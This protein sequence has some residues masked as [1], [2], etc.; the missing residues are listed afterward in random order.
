MPVIRPEFEIIIS[1]SDGRRFRIPAV[2]EIRVTSSRKLRA[3]KAEISL[4]Y[5]EGLDLKTFA[6]GDEVDIKLG[7][8]EDSSLN[9]VFLGFVT[10]VKPRLDGV[11]IVCEDVWS[12]VKD[13]RRSKE[14]NFKSVLFSEIAKDLIGDITEIE[15]VS[16][17]APDTTQEMVDNFYVDRQTYERIFDELCGASGWDF[18]VIPGTLQ[19]YF[20]PGLYRFDHMAQTAVPI[21]RRGLNVIESDLRWKEGEDVDQINVYSPDKEFQRREGLKEPL[22]TYTKPEVSDPKEIRDLLLMGVNEADA[23]DRARMEFD[24]LTAAGFEGRLKTFG[25]SKLTHSMK[26]RLEGLHNEHPE[27]HGFIEK[28]IY[29]FGP[30]AGFKMEVYLDPA[31]SVGES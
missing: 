1:K 10:E 14:Y 20:G 24:K 16:I 19:F 18:F 30:E 25:Q 9:S 6:K 2:K 5:M 15:E 3:D 11:D 28:I 7:H 29:S 23:D 17:L 31:M 27:V 13:R 4:P 22:G 26:C 12:L 8:A 21:F